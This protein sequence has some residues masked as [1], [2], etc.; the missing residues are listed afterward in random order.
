MWAR[1][2]SKAEA[3]G[4]KPTS[5]GAGVGCVPRVWPRLKRVG[6]FARG[7]LPPCPGASSPACSAHQSPTSLSLPAPPSHPGHPHISA[8]VIPTVCSS[9]CPL[10]CSSEEGQRPLS[11]LHRWCLMDTGVSDWRVRVSGWDSG[12]GQGP[13]C[14]FSR[15]RLSRPDPGSS[16]PPGTSRGAGR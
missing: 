5:R 11:S 4:E 2:A 12:H 14:L 3:A 9:L 8:H 16:V 7:A 13:G 1:L 6:A 10:G 15:C